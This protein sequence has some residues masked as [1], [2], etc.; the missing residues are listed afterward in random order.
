MAL[1][2]YALISGILFGMFFALLGL[3]L[4]LIFGVMHVV[5]LA[6]GDM[7]MLGAYSAFWLFTLWGISPLVSIPIVLV[8]FFVFGCIIYFMTVPRLLHTDDPELMSFIL[9]FGVSQL[10]EALAVIG[11]GNSQRSLPSAVFGQGPIFIL[12]QAFPRSW[13]FI[14]IISAVA[15]LVVFGYLQ[16]TRFGYGTRAVMSDR[17]E[18]ASV[19]VNVGRVSAINFGIGIALAALPGCFSSYIVGSITPDIGVQLTVIA[20]TVIVIGALE[21]PVGSVVG[22]II[23]GLATTFMQTYLP[24]WTN[25]MP[26]VLLIVVM[27]LRPSGLIGRRQVRSA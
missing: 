27:L 21:R 13:V 16:F 12:G 2:E 25:L 23:F 3:G 14:A 15:I 10:L 8:S 20:F 4:N 6:H 5:N 18:A 1:F 7:L 17:H 11:F 22:G 9:F 19:G 24:S 26:N